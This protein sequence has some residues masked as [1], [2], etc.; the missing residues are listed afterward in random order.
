[1]DLVIKIQKLF[2]DGKQNEEKVIYDAIQ[3]SYEMLTIKQFIEVTEFR[4]DDILPFDLMWNSFHYNIPV[5]VTDDL[6]E[7][8]GYKGELF[9]QKENIIKLV[10]KYNIPI[11]QLNNEEYKN[12]TH[13]LEQM[14]NNFTDEKNTL[15]LDIFKLYPK[16]TSKQLKSKPIHTL[17]MPR[18]LK[19][20]WLVVNT[21]NGDKIREYMI[22]LEELYNLY[23]KYQSE[24]KSRQMVIK[25]KK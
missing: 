16:I 6:I 18:N 21:F 13:L 9:K 8:F 25:D 19:K 1:M 3:A 5:Y 15:N 11:I 23:L 10:K 4:L 20:L 24:Y 7:V 17:I 22:T 14:P 12:F 2:Q